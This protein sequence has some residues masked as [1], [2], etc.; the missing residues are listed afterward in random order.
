MNTSSVPQRGLLASIGF[1]RTMLGLVV[2][3]IAALSWFAGS[4]PTGWYVLPVYVAPVLA[5]LLLWGLIL[6]LIM[7]RVYMSEPA[8]EDGPSYGL[9]MRFD[10]ALFAILLVSWG[11]FFYKLVA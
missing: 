6:D 5:I 10:L 4:E 8:T 9:V 1:L 2:L 3:V 7:T 11:P